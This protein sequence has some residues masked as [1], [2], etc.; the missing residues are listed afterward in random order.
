MTKFYISDRFFC[1]KTFNSK[2]QRA[3]YCLPNEFGD[4]NIILSV[5]A[6]SILLIHKQVELG[7][8]PS[9]VFTFSDRS[10][11]NCLFSAA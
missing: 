4:K 3:F 1:K 10:T 8:V 5:A 9:A 7:Q 11:N 2:L 6:R